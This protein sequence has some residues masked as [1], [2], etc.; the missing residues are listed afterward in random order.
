MNRTQLTRRELADML[1]SNRDTV[2]YLDQGFRELVEKRH[3]PS[4]DDLQ[5]EDFGDGLISCR[6]A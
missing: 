2:K 3:C 4:G 1:E 5:S 6:T